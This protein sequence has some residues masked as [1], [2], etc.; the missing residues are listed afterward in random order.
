MKE[1]YVEGLPA[2]GLLLRT[3]WLTAIRS[4]A[5]G[6]PSCIPPYAVNV[7]LLR[8]PRPVC[9]RLVDPWWPLC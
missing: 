8:P 7:L 4:R 5:Q 9:G 6:C 2:I 1:G 3:V